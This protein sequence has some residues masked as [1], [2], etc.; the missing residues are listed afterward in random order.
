MQN[1]NKA[2]NIDIPGFIQQ[3][4]EEPQQKKDNSKIYFF[5]S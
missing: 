3:D 4:V 5:S 2:D 1:Q